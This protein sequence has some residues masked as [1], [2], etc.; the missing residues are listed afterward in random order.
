MPKIKALKIHKH[1]RS[2]EIQN[3]DFSNDNTLYIFI[4]L[5]NNSTPN[6]IKNNNLELK[7]FKYN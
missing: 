2:P 3:N 6:I 7:V 4:I 5:P 1:K